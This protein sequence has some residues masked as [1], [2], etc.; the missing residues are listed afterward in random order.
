M[1][2]R[3]ACVWAAGWEVD[4]GW[5]GEAVWKGFCREG[6]LRGAAR[7]SYRLLRLWFAGLRDASPSL[8]I[9]PMPMCLF[10]GEVYIQRVLFRNA[11]M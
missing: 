9:T 1:C 2:Q 11:A 5:V 3:E 8:P 10:V 7:E 6:R 4:G